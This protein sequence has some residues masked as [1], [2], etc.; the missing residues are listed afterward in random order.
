MTGVYLSGPM[1]GLPLDNWPA[2][3]DASEQLRAAGYDVLSPAE[4]TMAMGYDPRVMPRPDT[5]DLR[6]ALRWDCD[7]VLRS[8]A[9][10]VMDGWEQSLGCAAETALAV[11]AG[12]R[13][14][15]L[16]VALAAPGGVSS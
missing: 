4:H 8:D 3:L 2:F 9:V 16:R 10:V 5:F 15:P 12:I 13:V 11:A 6:A 14:V 7:A 1:R